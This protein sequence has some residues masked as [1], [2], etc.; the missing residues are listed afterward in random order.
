VPVDPF[1][2]ATEMLRLLRDRHVSAVELIDLHLQRIE[3]YNPTLHAIVTLDAECARERA[4]RAD[5]E[6][7]RGI[8]LPLLGLPLTIKDAIDVRGLPTTGGLRH[9]REVRAD[10]DAPLVARLRQAGAV[11]VG[12]TNVPP[13]VSDWQTNNPIF[14]RTVNPWDPSRTPGGSTG[15][16]AAAVAAGLSPLE[17]GSDLGGSIRVPASF[18]GI[19]GHRPSETVAPRGG[20]FPGSPLLDVAGVLNVLGPLARAAP[21]LDLAL[22]VVAGPEIGEDAAWRLALPPARQERLSAFRVAV[23]PPIGWQP[24]SSEVHD[25]LNLLVHGLRDRGVEVEEVQPEAFGDLR[26]HHHLYA[27]LLAAVF[28]FNAGISEERRRADAVAIRADGDE[29]AES[30]ARG[31]TGSAHDLLHWLRERE[32][33]RAS[34]RDFFQRWDVLLAPVTLGPAFEHDDRPLSERSL[35]VD[36]VAFPYMRHM[37]YP[38]I[39]TLS[40]QPA[41]A[42][43]VAVSRT[44]LPIGLQVIGPYLEDRTPIR[45]ATLLAEEFGGYSPPPKYAESP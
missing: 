34:Y 3:R 25:A 29:F 18:C 28:T 7:A 6:R 38:G 12:K 2:S 41:T 24:V 10:A 43:P 22:Q 42:F 1:S 40:G 8:D 19:Y 17:F 15:G 45:F 30:R 33:Y 37:V 5:E 21:D 35:T 39:A 27:S 36:G 20:H 31:M 11:I 26:A 14:G 4:S 9:R 44:G 23:L 32:R 16:G 13:Y